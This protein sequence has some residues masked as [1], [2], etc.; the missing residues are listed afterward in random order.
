MGTVFFFSGFFPLVY[1]VVWMCPLTVFFGSDVYSAAVTFS[2]FMGGLTFGNLM[3]VLYT[4]PL[5]RTLVWYGLLEVV[6]GL[7][8]LFL[9]ER[10]G[11]AVGGG[12]IG[13]VNSRWRMT[14]IAWSQWRGH[15]GP[16]SRVRM[17]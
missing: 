5:K 3:A 6:I 17:C 13:V 8:V 16:A 15:G 10:R 1:E 9:P 4:D 12:K 7:Y 2:V 11:V 14:R